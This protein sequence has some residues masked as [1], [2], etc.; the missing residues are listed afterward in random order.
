MKLPSLDPVENIENSLTQWYESLEHLMDMITTDPLSVGRVGTLVNSMINLVTKP[1][2]DAVIVLCFFLGIFG[3]AATMAEAKRPEAAV[4]L[5]VRTAVAGA[6]VSSGY[7]FVRRILDISLAL[8]GDLNG[9]S[10][11]GISAGDAPKIPDEVKNAIHNMTFP[12]NIGVFIIGLIGSLAITV[13]GFVV[14][15]TVYGRWFKIYMYMII[16]P[17]PLATFASKSTQQVGIQF[18]RNYFAATLEGVVMLLAVW[19]YKQ[20]ESYTTWAVIPSFYE[21]SLSANA[22]VWNY[23][24]ITIFNMLILITII[25]S[26]N[27]LTREMFGV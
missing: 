24:Q 5:F 4:R 14:L 27:Q 13:C 18:L 22:M 2:G 19:A 8:L 15:L 1:V 6:F 25:K 17:I 16:S 7:T 26:S 3:T 23:L 9:L 21:P 10:Y 11:V 20:F 12:G